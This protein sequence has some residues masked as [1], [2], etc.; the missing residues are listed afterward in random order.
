[1]GH[2][3]TWSTGCVRCSTIT[4]N[5][6]CVMPALAA[7]SSSCQGSWTWG[8]FEPPRFYPAWFVFKMYHLPVLRRNSFE[9]V[10]ARKASYRGS[11]AVL[12]PF[13]E[14][15]R[16]VFPRLRQHISLSLKRGARISLLTFSSPSEP[17][18]PVLVFPSFLSLPPGAFLARSPLAA[19]NPSTPARG[20]MEPDICV[21][22]FC[23]I[24]C[25]SLID[26]SLIFF[27]CWRGSS[28]ICTEFISILVA[29]GSV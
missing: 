1:M 12:S 20:R 5:W 19:P 14:C 11:R 23:F 10:E 24:V 4:G 9:C 17:G 6:L 15:L 27:G 16:S 22:S 25:F 28:L 21:F 7:H 13:C 29:V 26:G 18:P 2:K 3:G 8:L